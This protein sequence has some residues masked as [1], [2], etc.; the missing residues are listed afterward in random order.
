MTESEYK[1][2]TSHIITFYTT[3]LERGVIVDGEREKPLLLSV[4]R[5]E[6]V[7]KDKDI[8]TK[9]IHTMSQFRCWI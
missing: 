7:Q 3:L 8:I 5:L 4:E 2:L 9:V 6:I 1:R